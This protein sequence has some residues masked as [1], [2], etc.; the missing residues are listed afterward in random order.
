MDTSAAGRLVYLWR[1]LTRNPLTVLSLVALLILLVM[2]FVPH[3]LTRY[4]PN[5]L[6]ALTRLNAPSAEHWF[7]TDHLGRDVYTRIIYGT[8]ARSG[9]DPIVAPSR[10]S[11]RRSG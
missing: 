6:D 8:R 11:A 7:G 3:W 2:S 10:P 1:R 5:E 4:P 9:G